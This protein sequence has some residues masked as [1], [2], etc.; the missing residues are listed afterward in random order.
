MEI[1]LLALAIGVPI[2]KLVLFP[3][4]TMG[5]GGNWTLIGAI[6][7]VGLMMALWFGMQS[8]TDTTTNAGGN[9]STASGS[10]APPAGL[11]DLTK[12]F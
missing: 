10:T 4:R 6:M 7:I 5:R 3:A 2:I 9:S 8:L 1:L 12:L 11:D